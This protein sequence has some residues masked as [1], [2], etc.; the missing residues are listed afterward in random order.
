L[1]RAADPIWRDF[2]PLAI[3]KVAAMDKI[4]KILAKTSLNL[5]IAE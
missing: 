5:T 2:I 3:N 4:E 1:H